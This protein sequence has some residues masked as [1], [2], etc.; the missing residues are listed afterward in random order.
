MNDKLYYVPSLEEF[1]VGFQYERMNGDKW[2]SAVIDVNDL[3]SALDSGEN[4]IE[5][6]GKHLRDVRV[7]YL[8]KELILELGWKLSW[9]ERYKFVFKY[10]DWLLI[11]EKNNRRIIITLEDNLLGERFNGKLKNKNELKILMEWLEIL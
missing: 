6:I 3:Y 9:E 1:H 8:D 4:E 2:E 10:N 7:K 11:Y 5:E